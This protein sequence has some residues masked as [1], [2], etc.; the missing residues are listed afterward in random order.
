[1]LNS[2]QTQNFIDSLYWWYYY[3]GTVT[4]C[5]QAVDNYSADRKKMLKMSIP[6]CA[7]TDEHHFNAKVL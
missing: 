6:L 3:T 2:K 4:A 5:R 1:M 7:R